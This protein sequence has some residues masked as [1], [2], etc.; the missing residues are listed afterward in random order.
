M[1]LRKEALASKAFLAMKDAYENREKVLLE[2]K[3]KNKMIVGT[4]GCDVPDEILIAAGIF[5]V[6]IHEGGVE[7]LST[8]NRYLESSFDPVIRRQFE[9]LIDGT[10]ASLI[11]HLV[12]SQ[13]SD[14]FIRTYFYLRELYQNEPS[15]QAPPL[16]FID[17]Q[18]DRRGIRQL[19][20]RRTITRFKQT[21]EAWIG[22]LITDREMAYGIRVCN[23]D[24]QA[25]RE[26]CR[27]RRADECRVLGT[28]AQIVIGSSLFMEKEK[29]AALVRELTEE[30]RSWPVVEAKRIYA[31]GT[32]QSDLRL[33]SAIEEL[34][35]NVV[36]EDTEWGDRHYHTDA[37]TEVDPIWAIVDRYMFRLPSQ[38]KCR[39]SESVP[40][41]MDE[42]ADSR[43]CGVLY[44]MN[45]REES[46]SWNTP[47]QKATLGEKGIPCAE[48]L[49][50]DYPVSEQAHAEQI[51][52]IKELLA[53][54]K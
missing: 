1:A 45:K 3:A 40:L 23:E 6:R 20:N 10:Y 12:I 5:P 42:V 15:V 49:R 32:Y 2:M 46:A 39:I 4:L 16:T 34:G 31:T 28:E 13:S 17:W 19:R 35:G 47:A 36:G 37:S 53:K 9:K 44:Y 30:A 21:V 27:L 52:I 18:F 38:K 7:D 29:H 48:I 14:A 8:A 24:R 33:Y 54:I 25:M 51:Q 26:F 11:D 41:I 22:R 50:Q 43:A